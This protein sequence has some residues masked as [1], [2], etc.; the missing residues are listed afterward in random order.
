MGKRKSAA[1]PPPKKVSTD[2]V[3]DAHI[4]TLLD[5]FCI[6]PAAANQIQSQKA[7][8]QPGDE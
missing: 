7:A 5:F 2:V 1:K 3:F 8:V 6:S 4:S